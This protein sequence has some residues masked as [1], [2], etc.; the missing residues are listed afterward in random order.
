MARS[1]QFEAYACELFEGVGPV[2][3]RGMLGGAGLYVGDVM[4]AL[5]ADERIYLKTGDA[6]AADFEA[7][8]QQ[9]F[10]YEAKGG[11][12]A[13]MSYYELPERC[14]DDPDEAC[15]WGRA[16]LEVATTAKAARPKRTTPARR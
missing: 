1:K 6:T 15:A 9:P 10:T 5:I 2:R 11:R 16:A 12:R 13:V 7:E 4:F 8:G 3:A 14:L